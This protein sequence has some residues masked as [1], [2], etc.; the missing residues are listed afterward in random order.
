MPPSPEAVRR[1]VPENGSETDRGRSATVAGHCGSAWDAAAGSG[2]RVTRTVRTAATTAPARRRPVP[3]EAGPMPHPLD[4]LTAEE[5]VR[6]AG[7][8]RARATEADLLFSS[9]TLVEPSKASLEA[10]R[11]GDPPL[12]A[13]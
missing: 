5:I 13:A 10:H 1:I 3:W 4:P 11:Q 7:A 6:V 12:R 9:I 2:A 8:V